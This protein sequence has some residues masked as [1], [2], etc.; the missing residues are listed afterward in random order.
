MT[1][2]PNLDD[3]VSLA[4]SQPVP[5]SGTGLQSGPVS[6]PGSVSAMAVVSGGN[7]ATASVDSTR[8]LRIDG[9]LQ[10]D[11]GDLV[12]VSE[13]TEA[14]LSYDATNFYVVFV[15]RDVGP[16]QLRARM[17]RRESMFSDD[18]V[19]VHARHLRRSPARLQFFSNPLGIQ[20]DG[21]TTEGQ[22]DDMSFD[23][24]WQSQRPAD[25]VRLRRV[26]RDSVQEPP[27]PVRRRAGRGASR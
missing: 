4:S 26:L 10:R 23:T 8:G 13:P 16:S 18:F 15:C 25:G 22:D 9:F 14:F 19:A 12:P 20:A 6:A 7:S 5:Q 27:I 24:V 21:I 1:Q 2:P 11:P 17:A 3:Y